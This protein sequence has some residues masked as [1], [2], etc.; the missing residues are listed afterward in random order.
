[1]SK[2]QVAP[3]DSTLSTVAETPPT[4]CLE[5][6]PEDFSIRLGGVFPN[7][8]CTTTRGTFKFYDFLERGDEK[9]T[10]LFS[11]PRDFSAVST[12]EVGMCHKMVHEFWSRG[13]KPIA[14]SC[15]SLEEHKA[16]AKDC[17]AAAGLG[18]QSLAFPVI[19]DESREISTMLGLLDPL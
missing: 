8:E 4:S 5:N 17:L 12:T 6:A 1:M 14:L 3:G 15:D 19:A 11:H 2:S 18:G 10:C 16:W 13:V 9:W 7:F